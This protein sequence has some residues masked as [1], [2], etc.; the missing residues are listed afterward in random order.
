MGGRRDIPR[1]WLLGVVGAVVIG[2]AV[3][4]LAAKAAP[5]AKGSAASAEMAKAARVQEVQ[6][7]LEGTEWVLEL[8][9]MGEQGTRPTKDTLQFEQ[10]KVQSQQLAKTGFP[11]TNY[12]ISVGDD[13]TPVWET[14]QTAEDTSVVFWRGELYGETM[15]GIASKHPAKGQVMD[16]AFSGRR[17][18]AAAPASGEPAGATETPKKSRKQ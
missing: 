18:G 3:E 6:A 17:I 12:T 14:M 15:R 11:A 9:P 7:A 4:A 10:G 5:R 8:A 16:L 2:I 1:W 13:G